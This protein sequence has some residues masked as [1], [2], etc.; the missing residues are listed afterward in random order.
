[1]TFNIGLVVNPLAGLGGSVALKGSDNV[2][3]E[4][5]ALGAVPKANL[6]CIQALTEVA[7]LD[8]CV[9]AFAG[10]MGADCGLAAGIATEVIGQAKTQ[11][12]SAEDT[13]TAAQAL[14]KKGVDLLVFV[15]GD[16]TARD[17][18][19]AIGDQV[20]VVGIPAG[21]KI[22]S[23]V[24]GITPAA[25]GQVIAQLVKGE[26]VSLR[27]QE[28][29]DIDEEEFR[30]GRVKARY[31]GELQVPESH[32]Y[33]QATKDGAKEG[34]KEIEALVL[35]DISA[36]VEELMEPGVRYIMGSGSTVAAIMSYL[37]LENTLLGVDVIE[38]GQVIA[39]DVTA[40]QLLDLCDHH[41]AE[42]FITLI[43]G[44]GH[45]LGRGNQQLSPELIKHLGLSNIHIVAT[46]TKLKGLEGRPLLVDSGDPQLD[47]DLAGLVPVIC[48]FHDVV[49]Y[50]LGNPVPVLVAD[51]VGML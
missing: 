50:P 4:A 46:K 22:H 21:V 39:S 11:P 41:A 26:L 27:S 45:V 10:D 35:D 30:A 1:M 18:L 36:H 31:Y 51:T 7:G 40:Q 25:A 17:L 32:Q 33:M 13:M 38:D 37:D 16:G 49:L 28:V 19:Q 29:R 43:G 42:L 12:S 14:L 5:L 3:Q 15:G 47:K 9:Y 34:S 23:G 48:G 20:P 8:V 44:Q 24:Y 2:A 6:R